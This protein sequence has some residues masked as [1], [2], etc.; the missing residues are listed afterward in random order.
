VEQDTF[1]ELMTGE[2][3]WNF[4]FFHQISIK[5]LNHKVL[6]PEIREIEIKKRLPA[7]HIQFI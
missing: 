2:Y 1:L 3:I 5:L 7:P 4:L 6:I